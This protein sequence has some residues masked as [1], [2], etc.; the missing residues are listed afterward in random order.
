MNEI[1]KKTMELLKELDCI[2]RSSGITYFLA[3]GTLALFYVY[4]GHSP[5]SV[6]L[7]I[8]VPAGQILRLTDILSER[9]DDR[10][11]LQYMGNYSRH[12]DYQ[13]LYV[14]RT[15]TFIDLRQGWNNRA[16]GAR[17][18]IT[19][20]RNEIS[21]IRKTI[22]GSLETG[23]E[24]NGYRLTGKL[25]PKRI[26]SMAAVR[27]AMIAGRG[28]LAR[29][30]F[31]NSMKAYGSAMPDSGELVI[32]RPKRRSRYVDAGFF[33]DTEDMIIDGH[34][35]CVPADPAGFLSAY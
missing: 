2:C 9:K 24:C 32:R 19:P 20:L 14:D 21:G 27:A 29:Y 26:I 7:N 12:A 4:R 17:I 13:V 15:T 33:R 16:F 30:L 35:F 28:R 25:R 8:L 18:V 23:W 10:R 31:R 6:N 22:L 1:Q 11:E 3:P 5:Y 34:K